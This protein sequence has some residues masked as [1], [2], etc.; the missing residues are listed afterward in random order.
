MRRVGDAE[1]GGMPDLGGAPVPAAAEEE[2]AAEGSLE[3][4]GAAEER[5]LPTAGFGDAF[6]AGAAERGVRVTQQR[7]GAARHGAEE[8]IL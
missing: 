4:A 3:A 6:C 8:S 7:H 2:E 1:E 5:L